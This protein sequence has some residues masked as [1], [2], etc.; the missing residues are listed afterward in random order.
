MDCFLQNIRIV[1]NVFCHGQEMEFWLTDPDRNILF[2]RQP[3][4]LPTTLLG[5]TNKDIIEVDSTEQYQTMDGF[6]HALTGGSAF[7]LYRLDNVT[8]SRILQ[9]IFSTDQS[10]T[11]ISYLRISIDSS[12]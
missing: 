10:N 2:Q 9:E 6:G 7:H 5:S 1:I 8:R 3:S 4:I 11:G 12:D